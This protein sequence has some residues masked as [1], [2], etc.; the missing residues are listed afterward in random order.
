MN[1]NAFF[2]MTG[3]VAP[4][5]SAWARKAAMWLNKFGIEDVNE[6]VPQAMV[7]RAF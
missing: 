5:I 2:A 4:G 7:K 3:A 1:R 6:A